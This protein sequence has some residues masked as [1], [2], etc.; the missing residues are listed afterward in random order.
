MA[1][2]FNA[3]DY[4]LTY[5]SEFWLKID[6]R[7]PEDLLTSV[8][9]TGELRLKLKSEFK[10]VKCLLTKS[11]LY[12]LSKWN[13]PK[14]KVCINWKVLTGFVE[15]TEGAQ[16]FGFRLGDEI[17]Q[18]FY[19]KDENDLNQWIECLAK[20]TILNSFEE[21]VVVVKPICVSKSSEIFLCKYLEN[22]QEFVL[23]M[24]RNEDIEAKPSVFKLLLNEINALRALNS[25]KLVKMHRIYE[26]EA[27]VYLLLDYY[28]DGD[29]YQWYSRNKRK[30]KESTVV[31]IVREVLKALNFV[32]CMGIVHRDIKPEN[33]AIV[34]I[35]GDIAVKIIDFGLSCD[36]TNDIYQR[37][38]SPGY[39]APEIFKST[40]YNFKVDIFSTGVLMYKL[41]TGKSLFRGKSSE[42]ILE[43]NRK[44]E[45]NLTSKLLKKVSNETLDLLKSLLSIDP[46]L[47]CTAAEALTFTCITKSKPLDINLKLIET[48]P[49]SLNDA[50]KS[51]RF[52]VYKR[53]QLVLETL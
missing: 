45:F 28:P 4:K 25:D 17:F 35:N 24:F 53:K 32:H 40:G 12:Y 8:L 34:E 7:S 39:M 46:F 27:N 42:E 38:G 14:Y 15:E 31:K 9:H 23:K 47:R 16:V 43:S 48:T 10:V 13:L 49:E 5:N 18:D 20:A 29:L 6:P 22:G 19:V 2:V 11:H 33:L 3:L 37:C 1:S 30:M 36:C 26:T 52:V 50:S 21:D 41:L 51:D 44:C